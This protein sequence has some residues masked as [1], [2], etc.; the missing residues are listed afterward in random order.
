MRWIRLLAVLAIAASLTACLNAPPKAGAAPIATSLLVRNPTGFDIN[1]YALTMKG[2]NV[3]RIWLATVPAKGQRAFPIE[4]RMMQPGS[5][6]VV[7]T[8]A[9]GSSAV[10]TSNPV[11]LTPSLVGILDLTTASGGD[12]S[13]SLFYAVRIEDLQQAMR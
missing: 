4:P 2:E 6:L 10:W 5:D 9:V 3:D 12:C 8:Q 1:V 7:Q 11:Q 13:S